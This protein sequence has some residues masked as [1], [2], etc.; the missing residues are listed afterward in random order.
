[1]SRWRDRLESLDFT[2]TRRVLFHT[3]GWPDTTRFPDS[4]PVMEPDLPD[5]LAD[6]GV[7][8]IGVDLPSVDPLT[9]RRWT[10]TMRWAGAGSRLWKG[11]GWSGCRPGGTS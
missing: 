11:S 4:I 5:W 1:M 10:F 9:R 8:L 2:D 7:R 6:R 3:G